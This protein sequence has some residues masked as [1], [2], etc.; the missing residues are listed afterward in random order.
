M[1]GRS[2]LQRDTD[3]TFLAPKAAHIV[4]MA[5]PAVPGPD[6]IAQ[7]G[8]LQRQRLRNR[9]RWPVLALAVAGLCWRWPS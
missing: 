9:C 6:L 2:F 4:N 3:L 1:A 5:K 8:T 7:L